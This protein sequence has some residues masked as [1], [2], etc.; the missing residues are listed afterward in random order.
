MAAPHV[1]VEVAV[2]PATILTEGTGPQARPAE[3]FAVKVTVPA[4]LFSDLTV[5]G[6]VGHKKTP[7][8][9]IYSPGP[10]AT[11]LQ[12]DAILGVASQ[13]DSEQGT[14]NGGVTRIK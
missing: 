8:A 10:G 5:I 14:N 13:V 7:V 1:S 9:G 11:Y 2:P 12:Y 4:K 3:G 6:H